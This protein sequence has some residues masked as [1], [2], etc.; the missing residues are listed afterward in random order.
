MHLHLFVS[1]AVALLSTR[2]TFALE[3]CNPSQFRA[4]RSHTLTPGSQG[5]VSL[6]EYSPT[7]KLYLKKS[8]PPNPSRDAQQHHAFTTEVTILDYLGER[9][10]T[11]AP[12]LLCASHWPNMTLAEYADARDKVYFM[13]EYVNL[14]DLEKVASTK[15]DP[16]MLQSILQTTAKAIQGLHDLDVLHLD[17]KPANILT[18]GSALYLI[19][20]G[21]SVSPNLGIPETDFVHLTDDFMPPEIEHFTPAS[22]WYSLG[23]TAYYSR[24]MMMLQDT[25]YEAYYGVSTDRLPK[26]EA[27]LQH[28]IET[29]T[30]NDMTKRVPNGLKD[31]MKETY[32]N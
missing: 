8:I 3:L 31:L 24:V 20:F 11:Y 2:T 26:E 10:Y 17:I 9:G 27:A 4:L 14:K 29:C 7:Q 19:D 15:K 25:D 13:M 6:H 32:M 28:F 1:T 30:V 22:D 21:G 12:K 23:A 5:T 18:D 16:K